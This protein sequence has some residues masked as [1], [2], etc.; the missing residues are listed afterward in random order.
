VAVRR[1]GDGTG[2][3]IAGHEWEGASHRLKFLFGEYCFYTER[4]Q[5][6]E[7]TTH[8]SRIT[9]SLEELT[10]SVL[11]LLEEYGAAVI[12]AYPI[13]T[14]PRWLKITRDYVSYVPEVTVYYFNDSGKSFDSY[15]AQLP[16]K[17]QHELQR[18]L[19]RFTGYSGGQIDLRTYRSVAEAQI[20]EGLANAVSHKTYQHRLLGVGLPDTAQFKADLM[21]RASRDAMR[22]YL[23]FHQGTAIAYAYAITK[24]DCLQ[25]RC[26]GYDPSWRELSAGIVLTY[27][28]LRSAIGER[29]F[30]II[31]FGF[32][33]A[34]YKKDFAT[35]SLPCATVF[36][37]RP[38]IRNLLI[39][40]SHR[41][42]IAASDCF[43]GLTKR[44]G[45]KEHLKQYFRAPREHYRMRLRTHRES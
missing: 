2:L 15:A 24:G 21:D 40:L 12:P 1:T 29:R 30:A 41:A 5:A 38:A 26:I 34:R 11:P 8:V 16:G 44:L 6:A 37:F 43:S 13:S 7:L 25:F 27:H 31:D 3:V 14:R 33:E 19:R 9:G 22:G 45:I 32:G 18:K 23:L 39:V 35:G 20:F 10:P 36:L 17:V 42:C 4:F 28:A